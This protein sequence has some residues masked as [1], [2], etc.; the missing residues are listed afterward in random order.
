MAKRLSRA[1]IDRIGCIIVDQYDNAFPKVGTMPRRIDPANMA[2][3]VLGLHIRFLKL[4][5]DGSILGLACFHDVTVQLPTGG[6]LVMELQLSSRDIVLDV[7]LKADSMTGRRNFTT[8]HELAHHILI[9]LY[10]EYYQH[11]LGNRVEYVYR[12]ST[13]SKNWVE[14]QANSL[15]EVLLMPEDT[16]LSCIQ[17]F[18]FT[19]ITDAL[20]TG[21]DLTKEIVR[22]NDIAAYLSVSRQALAIRMKRMGVVNEAFLACF[23]FPAVCTE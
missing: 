17:M 1:D 10:P 23:H 11:D 21:K 7:S 15:A 13:G 12:D 5:P 9:R 4:S 22:F 20:L 16:V 18:G 6:G 8:A 19:P 3:V 14:W 2:E